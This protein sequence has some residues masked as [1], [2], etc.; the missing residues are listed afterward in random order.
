MAIR[1]RR[2]NGRLIALCAA[3]SIEKD[4]D[5]YNEIQQKAPC[6]NRGMN[7]RIRI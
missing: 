7:A 6:F 5:I 4:G 2:V 3:R 1:L